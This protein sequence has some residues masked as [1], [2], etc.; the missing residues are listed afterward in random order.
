MADVFVLEPFVAAV[1][2]VID[3]DVFGVVKAFGHFKF[4][5]VIVD[6][7]DDDVHCF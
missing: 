5:F 7:R 3:T 2:G 6:Y 4:A 1:Q